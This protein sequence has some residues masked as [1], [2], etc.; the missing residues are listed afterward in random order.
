MST[1]IDIVL[2]YD[3]SFKNGHFAT[4]TFVVKV[5]TSKDFS[6]VLATVIKIL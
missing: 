6:Q 1:E 2:L 5:K 3:F 4:F